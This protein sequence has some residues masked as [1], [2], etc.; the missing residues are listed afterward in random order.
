MQQFS[1]TIETR[2]KMQR[3][4]PT[5]SGMQRARMPRR[6]SS[7]LFR[8]F[9][10][11]ETRTGLEA[12]AEKKRFACCEEACA[13]NRQNI[14]RIIRRNNRRRSSGHCREKPR[15]CWNFI[16]CTRVSFFVA[17]KCVLRRREFFGARLVRSVD[18]K[19]S[20][21]RASVHTRRASA[22]GPEGILLPVG[23]GHEAR[24]CHL[25]RPSLSP[26]SDRWSRG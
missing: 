8:L 3:A 12:V 23:E 1:T 18:W 19:P 9:N 25:R 2:A 5:V 15:N 4:T 6:G 20:I 21:V 24:A 16:G 10:R 26:T 7:L 22:D 11:G 13:E 17:T 14:R